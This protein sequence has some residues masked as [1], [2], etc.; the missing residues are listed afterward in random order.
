MPYERKPTRRDYRNST[1]PRDLVTGLAPVSLAV[2]R[3][4]RGREFMAK[5]FVPLEAWVMVAL[6]YLVMTLFSAC[7]AAW[8]EKRTQIER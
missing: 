7:V 3:T 8:V 1:Y 4:R 6:L 2:P 5:T